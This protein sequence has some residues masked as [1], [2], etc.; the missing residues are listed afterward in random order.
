MYISVRK[1]I[2]PALIAALALSVQIAAGA[3]D[4]AERDMRGFDSTLVRQE[5]ARRALTRGK[6]LLDDGSLDMARQSLTEAL[7]LD[8]NLHEARFCLGLTEYRDGKY[9]LA[10]AQFESLYQRNPDFRKVRLE[11]ARS[12]LAAGDCEQ[13][14]NWLKNYLKKNKA[15]KDTDK[16]KREIDKCIRKQ[17]R[18]R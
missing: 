1:V 11:L 4:D 16:L 5:K 9:K 17:E 13:A 10:V 7:T 3:Q 12:Y 18:K 6:S 8:E 14:R 15:E 2:Y